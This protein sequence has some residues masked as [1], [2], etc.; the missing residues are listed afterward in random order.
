MREIF[1]RASIRKFKDIEV[2]DEKIH[3]ILNAA[4]SAPS[5]KNGRPW[6]FYVVKDRDKLIE[7]S[8]ATPYSMCV[9]NAPVAIVVCY[10]ENCSVPEFC[11]IDCAIATQ[12]MLL[13][14]DSLELGG[15]MIGLSP[16]EDRMKK[17]EEI[18]EIPDYLHSFTIVPFGYP[19]TYKNQENRFEEDRVHYIGG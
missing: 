14:I 13:M 12:N 2:E 7:L 10:R 5:A 8:M 4:M 11:N 18:L 15:V 17:V 3:E 9:K 6:E 19:I 1:H 16:D